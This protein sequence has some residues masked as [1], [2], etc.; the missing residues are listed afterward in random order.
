[1]IKLSAEE[2]VIDATFYA[3]SILMRL[4]LSVD[5][6]CK[7]VMKLPEA[8]GSLSGYAFPQFNDAIKSMLPA[9]VNPDLVVAIKSG[10]NI[11]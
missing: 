7:L 1:M 4:G 3:F 6:A 9:K 8:D 5:Q 11:E 2:G 10:T